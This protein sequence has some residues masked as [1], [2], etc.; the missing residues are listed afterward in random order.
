MKQIKA[1]LLVIFTM[2]IVAGCDT[3]TKRHYDFRDQLLKI[4]LEK[5]KETVKLD[6]EKEKTKQEQMKAMNS[7]AA[8][9][10]AG[11]A[12]AFAVTANLSGLVEAARG[13]QGPSQNDII[14]QQLLNEKPPKTLTEEIRDWFGFALGIYRIHVDKTLGLANIES[15]RDAQMRLYELLQGMNAQAVQA[16]A[17]PNNVYNVTLNE[18]QGN[19]LFGGTASYSGPI[20][21]S[22]QGSGAAAP[23]GSSSTGGS[24]STT[25]NGASG[26]AM[27][28]AGA[29]AGS[30]V[31]CVV[32]PAR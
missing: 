2:L 4:M 3:A 13:K 7:V 14:F 8:K 29:A 9:L 28:G 21:V 32:R 12:A 10:D 27:G 19:S 25:G 1:A 11:G 23:G 22:C 16:G 31:N 15:N 20:A 26:T 17:N 24:T 6:I 5:D 30:P 18:S